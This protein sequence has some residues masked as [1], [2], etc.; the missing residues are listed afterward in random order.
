MKT[1][2]VYLGFLACVAVVTVVCAIATFVMAFPM[3]SIWN[4]PSVKHP[5]FEMDSDWIATQTPSF[6]FHV[7]SDP[8]VTSGMLTL[9]VESGEIGFGEILLPLPV[10]QVAP[11]FDGEIS[12]F[13]FLAG[14]GAPVFDENGNV[15][16]W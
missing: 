4:K 10:G 15:G 16:V 8:D 14:D 7:V 3:L 2:K 1:E 12:P 6:Q 13:I 5:Q 9:N 11:G